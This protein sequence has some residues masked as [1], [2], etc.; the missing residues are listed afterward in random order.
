MAL[1][2]IGDPHLSFS[3]NKPMDIFGPVWQNHSEKLRQGFLSQVGPEDT[4]VLCGDL[5]WGMSLDECADDFRFLD[6]LPG[7]TKLLVKGNHDYWWN[8]MAKME[9]FFRDIGCDSFRILQN[10]CH[11]YGD[12]ALCA[13][14]GW[15]FELDHQQRSEKMFNREC[16][17]LELALKAAGE[18]EKI[19]FLHYPPIYQGYR[20]KPVLDL[21]HRYGVKRCCYA[22]LHGKMCRQAIEGVCDGIEFS[23]ISAD[24]LG[25]VPKRIL[26]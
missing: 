20:C 15:F 5:S 24:H 2:A 16:I 9:G 19:V 8:S 21:L 13:T 17:R 23:L 12:I 18:R 14:R 11:L 7:E 22:H 10:N 6:A 26:D 1:F 25:F 3:V 4:V